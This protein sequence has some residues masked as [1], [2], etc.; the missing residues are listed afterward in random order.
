MNYEFLEIGTSDFDTLVQS[1]D[2]NTYGISV[3]PI[4]FYLDRLPDRPHCIKINAAVVTSEQFVKNSEIDVYYIDQET[5]EKNSL[6][7]WLKGC[8]SVGKPHDFHVTYYPDAG[9]WHDSKDRA[10]LPTENLLEKGLVTVKKVP[11]ITFEMIMKTYDIEQ[12]IK[13]KTDTEG[14]DADLLIDIMNYYKNNDKLSFLPR[15][16]H[17]EDN[18][19]T[20]QLRMSEAKSLMKSLGYQLSGLPGHDSYAELRNG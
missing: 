2:D 14:Q 7:W 9:V 17:F 5:I 13:L 3:E 16:I 12:I 15:Q 10:S 1:C 11:A 18:A 20:D 8:N 6:G 4:D 19:H